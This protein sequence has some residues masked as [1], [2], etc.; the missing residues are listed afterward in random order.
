MFK[1]CLQ[2]SG[3]LGA[4][5][6][7]DGHVNVGGASLIAVKADLVLRTR[8]LDIPVKHKSNVLKYRETLEAYQ[9]LKDKMWNKGTMIM[10]DFISLN[11]QEMRRMMIRI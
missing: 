4:D 6:T 8:S 7:P 9:S 11:N 5:K 1:V 2:H 3:A 10:R